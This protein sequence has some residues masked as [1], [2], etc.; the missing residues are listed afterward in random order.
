MCWDG[1]AGMCGPGECSP[2]PAGQTVNAKAL[3]KWP[4]RKGRLRWRAARCHWH[5]PGRS[6]AARSASTCAANALQQA[7]RS[8]VAPATELCNGRTRARETHAAGGD[9]PLGQGDTLR[10][11]VASAGG[12]PWPPVYAQHHER[13]APFFLE[14]MFTCAALASTHRSRFELVRWLCGSGKAIE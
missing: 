1:W 7:Q 2:M 9:R 6:R 14:V 13:R 10:P 11:G 12:P 4:P 5:R 3:R 8:I